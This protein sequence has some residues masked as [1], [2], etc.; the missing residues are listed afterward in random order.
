MNR[1]IIENQADARCLGPTEYS[2]G[3][4]AFIGLKHATDRE[5]VA[6]LLLL[7]RIGIVRRLTLMIQTNLAAWSRV[8]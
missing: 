3:E 6:F 2:R 1:S 5:R 4:L 8:D 7:H